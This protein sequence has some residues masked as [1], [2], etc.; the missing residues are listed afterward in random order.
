MGVRRTALP[1]REQIERAIE[2]GQEVSIDFT[3]VDATQSFVDELVGV[4][5]AKR[6][7]SVMDHVVF[8]GCSSSVKA[9]IRFVVSDRASHFMRTAH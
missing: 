7:P 4:I 6:G 5:V 9:I 8:K 3:G 2:S 1:L